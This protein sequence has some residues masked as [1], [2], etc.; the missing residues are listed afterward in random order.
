MA[1][2]QNDRKQ[3]DRKQTGVKSAPRRSSLPFVII[4]VVLVAVVVAAAWYFHHAQQ[5]GAIASGLPGAQPAHALGA[6]GAPVTLEEF[7][8][9]QCPPCG[10]MF[11]EVEKI[12]QEYGGQLRFIFREFPLVRV[13]PHALLAAHA[14]EAAGLQNK[15]WE[16]QRAIFENQRTWSPAQDPTAMFED[17]ARGAGLDVDRYRRDLGS[18]ETD[19]RVVADRE[20]GQSIGVESTPTFFVNGR[21]VTPAQTTAKGLREEIEHALGK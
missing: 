2:K 10:Q 3:P 17:Y 4:G 16:M 12:R 7:G 9:F 15:F 8:D 6:D 1:K 13:H 5:P 19:A 11:P 14:A 21:K 18:S 20:R